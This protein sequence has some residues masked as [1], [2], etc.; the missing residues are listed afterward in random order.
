MAAYDEAGTSPFTA[1]PQF[2]LL[3]VWAT[4]A[5][6]AGYRTAFRRNI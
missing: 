5:I 6:V 4:T 3:M 1:T 2:G